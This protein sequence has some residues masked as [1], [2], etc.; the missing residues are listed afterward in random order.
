MTANHPEDLVARLDEGAAR[1]P[2]QGSLPA[3]VYCPLLAEAAATI[4]TRDETIAA[5]RAALESTLRRFENCA[6]HVGNDDETIAAATASARRALAFP[7]QEG[8]K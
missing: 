7:H 2:W 5:L 4:R 1:A 6:R 3:D 8:T